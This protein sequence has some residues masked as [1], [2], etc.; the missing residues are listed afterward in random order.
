MH[1]GRIRQ[2]IR[3]ELVAVGL[4]ER[5]TMIERMRQKHSTRD[6][7]VESVRQDLQ[8]GSFGAILKEWKPAW[9]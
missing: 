2:I 9:R 7:I 5:P 8:R 4:S 6:I 1:E 3:E